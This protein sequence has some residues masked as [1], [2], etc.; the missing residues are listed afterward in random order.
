MRPNKS[1]EMDAAKR[2]APLN[3]IVDGNVEAY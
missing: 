1:F 2:A 3:S